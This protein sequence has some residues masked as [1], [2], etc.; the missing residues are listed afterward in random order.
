MSNMYPPKVLEIMAHMPK[1]KITKFA[2]NVNGGGTQIV[3]FGNSNFDLKF[4]GDSTVQVTNGFYDHECGYRFHSQAASEELIKFL[5]A[6]GGEEKTVIYFSEHNMIELA[7]GDYQLMKGAADLA[8]E[9]REQIQ[10]EE[11]NLN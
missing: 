5:K 4:E 7:K 11:A 1:V 8:D 3:N 2:F 9:V 10:R 6:N